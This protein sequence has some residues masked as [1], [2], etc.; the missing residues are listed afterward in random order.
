FSVSIG[1][2]RFLFPRGLPPHTTMLPRLTRVSQ[3]RGGNDHRRP[4]LPLNGLLADASLGRLEKAFFALKSRTRTET[5]YERR[6]IPAAGQSGFWNRRLSLGRN[7]VCA[8][9]AG[10]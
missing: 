2:V 10:H 4:M 3:A 5:N 9:R 6:F 1:I 8:E 7:P